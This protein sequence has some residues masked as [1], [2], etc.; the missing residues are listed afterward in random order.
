MRAGNILLI[1]GGVVAAA[2][3]TWF[4]IGSRQSN[5]AVAVGPATVS[6]SVQF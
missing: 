5:A 4:V 1:A 3:I 6:L 2:G